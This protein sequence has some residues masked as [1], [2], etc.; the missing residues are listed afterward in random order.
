[1]TMILRN[2]D[3]TIKTFSERGE[4]FTPQPGETLEE[5]E[6]SFASYAA[7]L[8]ISA[9]QCRGETLRLPA[10]TGA[11]QV[12]VA[13]PGE[14]NVL[15][16]VNNDVQTIPLRD[17]SGSFLLPVEDGCAYMIRPHDRVRYCA[18]GEAL[19]VVMVELH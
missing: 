6:M 9:G 15:L 5:V 19:M 13:C 12:Q 10:G 8:R 2:A 18:A 11:V 4:D 16:E 1:M 17:G 3:R 7:R 14:E